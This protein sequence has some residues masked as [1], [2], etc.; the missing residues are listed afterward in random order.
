MM[1]NILVTGV[2][3]EV[4]YGLVKK[5]TETGKYNVVALDIKDPEIEASKNI[6][7]FY[8]GNI[9]DI[10]SLKNIFETE[11]IDSVIHLASILS[12]GGEKNPEL[13][14]D[15][16]VTGTL[17][18]FK[19]ATEYS[20]KNKK[21]IKFIFPSSIAA[22]GNPITIY[23]I[24]KQSCENIGTYFSK[25][26]KA[27]DTTIDRNNLIDFR[28]V[29]F[30]GLLSPDTLP[31]GGTSDYGPEM[32][33]S[34]AQ[35]KEYECFVRP[36]TTIPFMAMDDAVEI[37]YKLLTAPKENLSQNV[38]EVSGFSVSAKEI[39]DEVK[40]AFP[41]AKV[42]YKINEV[43]QKIVD[44]WPKEVGSEKA[45]ADWG[46]D[47]KYDFKSTFTN[48]LIPKIKERYSKI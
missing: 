31:S 19:L 40:L 30:P 28:C 9:L 42:S 5:L 26:Y 21:S 23:G 45:I 3:G 34:A 33:H 24:S 37:L 20:L 4:G 48:Y 29:R 2:S 12:T 1:E 25:D 17:N 6:N 46:Y 13:A 14:A 44:S 43:R 32:L 18:L 22:D 15:I 10:E 7:K 8:K 11:N 39:E 35:G 16:N 38:Y 41:D 36:D 27:L 47:L